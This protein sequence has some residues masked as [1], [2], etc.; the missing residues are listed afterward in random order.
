MAAMKALVI[1]QNKLFNV[2]DIGFQYYPKFIPSRWF[3]CKY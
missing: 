3:L 1:G 2:K